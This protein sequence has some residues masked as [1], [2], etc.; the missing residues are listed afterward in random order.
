[1]TNPVIAIDSKRAA[2][3]MNIST[4]TALP[5]TFDQRMLLFNQL[6][7]YTSQL[8]RARDSPA[9]LQ[10][11]LKGLQ[12]VIGNADQDGL[13]SHGILDYILFPLMPGVDSIVLI[14]RS[15][16]SH[17]TRLDRQMYL[18]IVLQLAVE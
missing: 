9:R 2:G 14:R 13:N 16:R 1:M 11:L 17:T 18:G 10:S 5:P 3:S 12:G 8:L 7:P 6:K 15:G 4:A